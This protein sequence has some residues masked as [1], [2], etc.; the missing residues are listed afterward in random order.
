MRVLLALAFLGVGVIPA[1]GV[2]ASSPVESACC[3]FG[4]AAPLR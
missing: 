1:A 3:A 4:D 2:L